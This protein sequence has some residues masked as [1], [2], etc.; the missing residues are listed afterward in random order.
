[1]HDRARFRVICFA[2]QVTLECCDRPLGTAA[3]A[4]PQTE[5]G[6][7]PQLPPRCLGMRCLGM[8]LY[9]CQTAPPPQTARAV[10]RCGH[11]DANAGKQYSR[12]D[13]ATHSCGH[14]AVFESAHAAIHSC[15][16]T[17]VCVYSTQEEEK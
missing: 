6:C 12:S 7:P 3:K 13:A 10:E 8:L 11:T 14:T 15:G 4:P 16:H 1:M 2:L 5:G 9:T 17:A